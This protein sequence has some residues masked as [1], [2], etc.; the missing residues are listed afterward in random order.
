MVKFNSKTK[1]HLELVFGAQLKARDMR[2]W[3]REYRF[4]KSLKTATGRP[5]MWRFDWCSRE[6]LVAVEIEGGTAGGVWA[7]Q[8][9]RKIVKYG[10]A[11]GEMFDCLKDLVKAM[12]RHVSTKGFEDDCVKYNAAAGL[13]WT[14]LRGTAA[15]VKDMSLIEAAERQIEFLQKVSP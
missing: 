1:D 9:A 15:M 12:G 11:P 10:G 14:V 5:R 3:E 4:A 6:Y 7:W 2:G 13:G 8:K